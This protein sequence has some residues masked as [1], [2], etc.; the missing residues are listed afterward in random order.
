LR[1]KGTKNIVGG[2]GR[3]SDPLAAG[4]NLSVIGN[5]EDGKGGGGVGARRLFGSSKMVLGSDRVRKKSLVGSGG[6]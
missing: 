5:K 1:L 6:R 2:E 3:K 4:R